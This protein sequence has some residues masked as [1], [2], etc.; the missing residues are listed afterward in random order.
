MLNTLPKRPW[1]RE[2]S[3]VNL[4]N[5]SGE[6]THWVCFKKNQ[7]TVDYFDSYGDLRP[8]VEIQKYLSG[9]YISYNRTRYQKGNSEICGHLCLAFLVNKS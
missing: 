1:K 9:A 4:D 6:G 3:I 7:N 8:P 2:A 5:S